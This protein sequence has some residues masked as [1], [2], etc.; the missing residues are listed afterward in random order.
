MPKDL[1]V[2]HCSIWRVFPSGW[3]SSSLGGSERKGV[4]SSVLIRRVLSLPWCNKNHWTETERA[5]AGRV[6]HSWSRSA[7]TP[8]RICAK[9]SGLLTCPSAT[10][11]RNSAL[12]S[13]PLSAPLLV[14]NYNGNSKLSHFRATPSRLPSH[15]LV[16]PKPGPTSH[17]P[18]APP[19]SSVQVRITHHTHHR[20][21]TVLINK[22]AIRHHHSPAKPRYRHTQ[23]TTKQH[24][25]SRSSSIQQ[26]PRRP[27]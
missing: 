19:T 23:P 24:P 12:L 15:S 18:P 9:S 17:A 21:V 26:P 4:L 27:E 6:P 10:R 16:R 20:R 3:N 25:S 2:P 11:G 22:H 7:A 14:P 13:A 5:P 1:Q 8:F